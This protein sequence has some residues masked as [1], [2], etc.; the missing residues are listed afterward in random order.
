MEWN[1]RIMD[2]LLRLSSGDELDSD[3]AYF[4]TSGEDVRRG[5][6]LDGETSLRFFCANIERYVLWSIM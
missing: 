2:I 4:A 6:R 5:R 3:S 1:N